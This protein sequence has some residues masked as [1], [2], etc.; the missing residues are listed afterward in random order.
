LES[1]AEGL[2]PLVEPE[3]ARSFSVGPQDGGVALRIFLP[4]VDPGSVTLAR[5]RSDLIVGADGAR[6][7]ISL[8]PDLRAC[9][10]VGAEFDGQ[11]LVVTFSPKR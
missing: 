6:R 1:L 11:Y 8:D 9:T 3:A 5:I 7:R 10:V 4:V 2:T